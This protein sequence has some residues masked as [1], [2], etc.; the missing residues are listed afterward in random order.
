MALRFQFRLR[1]LLL[2]VL[3][4]GPLLA[5]VGRSVSTTIQQRSFANAVLELG[6]SVRI[7][8]VDTT[9][10]TFWQTFAG[11]TGVAAEF[12]NVALTNAQLEVLAARPDRN[13]L[14]SLFLNRSQ[15]SD[16]GLQCLTNFARLRTLGLAGCNVSDEGVQALAGMPSL[17]SLNLRGTNVSGAGIRELKKSLPDCLVYR[18]DSLDPE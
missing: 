9:S 1:T 14:I 4:A 8:S 16:P 7:C 18:T 3:F 15:V 17:T 12:R 2:A 5:F 6:G 10:P 11:H 13:V